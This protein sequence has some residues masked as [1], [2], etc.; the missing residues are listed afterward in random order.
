[1]W[2]TL[3]DFRA[4]NGCHGLFRSRDSAILVRDVWCVCFLDAGNS[5][6]MG[7]ERGENLA[8]LFADFHPSISRKIGRKKFHE[9]SSTSFTGHETK[10]SQSSSG[11]APEGETTLLHSSKCSRPFI[12]SVKSTLSHLKTCNPVGGT[13]SS[14]A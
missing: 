6:H 14:T 4:E 5:A 8:K 10:F 1:M 7:E 3:A 11:G 9:K 13:P 12:Q 2:R